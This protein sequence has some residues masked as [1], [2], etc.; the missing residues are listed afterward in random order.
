MHSIF[1]H[2]ICSPGSNEPLTSSTGMG[3]IV[4]AMQRPNSG[5]EVRNRLWLKITIPS[6]FLGSDAVD[7]LFAN[8]Q[9][10]SDR[11]EARKFAAHMLKAKFFKQAVNKTS[12]SE[13]C[14]YTFGD[15][16]TI[17]SGKEIK[18][19]FISITL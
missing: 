18:S 4:R 8:V 17:A 10:F 15:E 1:L 2:R 7:W 13:Q 19:I 5:L 3:T 6:A 9:G 11:R 16:S 14:Y 12:F